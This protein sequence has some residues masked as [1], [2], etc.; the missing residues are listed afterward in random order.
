MLPG[1]C[2]ST[3]FPC[4]SVDF[5]NC[6]HGKY[7]ISKP[8]S[9]YLLYNS[10]VPGICLLLP[11]ILAELTTMT[12]F[13]LYSLKSIISPSAFLAEMEW[14]ESKLCVRSSSSICPAPPENAQ[15]T[16]L[17]TTFPIETNFRYLNEVLRNKNILR[18]TLTQ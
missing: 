16:I 1:S 15:L 3:L 14:N 13:P 2:P 6:L 9:L 7:R 10:M 12:I 17:D 4:S 5:P 18:N 8:W 11:H